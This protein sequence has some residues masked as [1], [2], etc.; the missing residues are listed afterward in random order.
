MSV[1][2]KF[3]FVISSASL[4]QCCLNLTESKTLYRYNKQ[5]LKVYPFPITFTNL[6]VSAAFKF[7]AATRG[8]SATALHASSLRSMLTEADRLGHALQFGV[9]AVM[10][11]TMWLLNL[12][13]R[14]KLDKN[15]VSAA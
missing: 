5:V 13:Q 7:A 6:Q 1:A 2:S 8:Y 14:P 3:H 10:A 4:A 12:H 15:V 9:G 11:L